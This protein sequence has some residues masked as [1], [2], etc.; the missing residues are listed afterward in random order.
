MMNEGEIV[1]TIVGIAVTGGLLIGAMSVY[2]RYRE[3]L[4][5]LKAPAKP[6]ESVAAEIEDLR[7]EV[8]ELRE[9]LGETTERID[10]AERMLSKGRHDQLP[11][12]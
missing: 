6:D 12:G 9:E 4:I 7:N 1:L 8:A 3:R 10:F 2:L 11:P 5:N